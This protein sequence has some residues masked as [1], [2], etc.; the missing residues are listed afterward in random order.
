MKVNKLVYISC[1]SATLAR[2]LKILC[3]NKYTITKVVAVDMF[4]HTKHVETVTLLGR[5]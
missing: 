5:K 1:N 3:E 2:D 4:P